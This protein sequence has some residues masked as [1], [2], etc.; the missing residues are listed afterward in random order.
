MAKNIQIFIFIYL[1]ICC[2]ETDQTNLED[3]QCSESIDCAETLSRTNLLE[4]KHPII[5]PGA[6]GQNSKLISPMEATNIAST[7][8]VKADVDFLQGMIVHHQQAIV[9]SQLDTKR[10]NNKTIL[11]LANRIDSSQEDEIDFMRSWLESREEALNMEHAHH[12]H[13]NM[14][15]MASEEELQQLRNSDSTEFDKLFLKLMINHHDGALEMVKVLK[16]YPGTAYDSIL[17][18]FI[19]ELVNDYPHLN[20]PDLIQLPVNPYT[21]RRYDDR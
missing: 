12:E 17:N 15:G 1:L 21:G 7:K 11:D 2:G 3:S 9:M 14:V 4:T 16:E 20:P 6:P 18:E 10:T 8:Y 19:S 5:L 13:M